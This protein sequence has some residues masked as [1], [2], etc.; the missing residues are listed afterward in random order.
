LTRLWPTAESAAYGRMPDRDLIELWPM[1]KMSLYWFGALVGSFW[2][3]SAY[4][5]LIHVSFPVGSFD[6]GSKLITDIDIRE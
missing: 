2:E 3:P 6:E 5:S 4:N 1:F